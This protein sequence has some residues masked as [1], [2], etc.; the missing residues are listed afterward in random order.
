M[1]IRLLRSEPAPLGGLCLGSAPKPPR[2]FRLMKVP[3]RS[4]TSRLLV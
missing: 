1:R 3:L 2:V 4:K